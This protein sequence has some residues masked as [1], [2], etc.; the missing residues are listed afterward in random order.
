MDGRML[1]RGQVGMEGV[2]RS[3]PPQYVCVWVT[4]QKKMLQ[5]GRE[6]VSTWVTLTSPAGAGFCGVQITHFKRRT[7]SEEHTKHYAS[8]WR[9]NLAKLRWEISHIYTCDLKHETPLVLI[10]NVRC[11]LQ[12]LSGLIWTSVA[13]EKNCSWSNSRL[14]FF[15]FIVHSGHFQLQLSLN[16][17]ETGI[18]L[19]AIISKTSVMTRPACE[20]Q[21]CPCTALRMSESLK[22]KS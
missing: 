16:M 12:S 9:L 11:S 13:S 2:G 1:D 3:P 21:R 14:L 8:M 4:S 22:K 17:K 19:F 10:K 20:R 6:G 18:F 15:D 5:P 7:E